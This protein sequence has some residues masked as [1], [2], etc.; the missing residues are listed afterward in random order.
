MTRL[1]SLAALLCAALL[2][3][4]DFE[5]N[6][7]QRIDGP[8]P[9]GAQI[10]FFNFGLNTTGV[11]FYADTRK[12]TAVN[13]ATGAAD[14]LGVRY[15]SAAAGG[16]YTQIDAGS[17][18]LMGKLAGTVDRDTAIASLPGTLETGKFY[19][20][21]LSGF[22]DTG[23]KRVDAFIVEDN[24]IPDFDYSAAYVRFVHTIANANPLTLYATI[25]NAVDTTKTDTLVVNTQVAYKSGGAFTPLQGGLYNLFVRYTDSTTN[26]ISRTGV[27]FVAG[28]IY[29]ISARGDITIT[30]TTATNRPFLDNTTNR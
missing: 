8:V 24:F 14:T 26:K 9:V 19:S 28:R 15:G 27:S 20:F 12:V 16:F 3:S 11:N 23:A 22:Y 17:Y 30:S 21:Y 29:T 4:C 2:A 5:K 1:S 6:T 25:R 10:K 18:T 7:V 13:S